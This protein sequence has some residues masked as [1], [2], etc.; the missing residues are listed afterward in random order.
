M[1]FLTR[2][3]EEFTSIDVRCYRSQSWGI[4]GHPGRS[5][6]KEVVVLG[7]SLLGCQACEFLRKLYVSSLTMLCF[8]LFPWVARLRYVSSIWI[9]SG[10]RIFLILVVIHQKAYTIVRASCTF[11]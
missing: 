2:G 4:Q 11:V 6:E 10:P 8:S 3:R 9:A 1:S 5:G 7:T